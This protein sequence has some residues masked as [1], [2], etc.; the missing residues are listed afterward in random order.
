MSITWQQR[1]QA[2][3]RPVKVMRRV[4][5]CKGDRRARLRRRLGRPSRDLP[6]ELFFE[7]LRLRTRKID[8]AHEDDADVAKAMERL[9]FKILCSRVQERKRRARERTAAERRPCGRRR[10]N[11][12][13]K[14][15]DWLTALEDAAADRSI[16]KAVAS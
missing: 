7:G 13:K 15:R 9:N 5:L 2:F 16:E 1:I 14:R 12:W 3:D 4:V 10:I 8:T 6:S 11:L